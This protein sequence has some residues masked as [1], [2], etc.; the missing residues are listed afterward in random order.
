MELDKFPI[1]FFDFGNKSSGNKI[2]IQA[3]TVSLLY[4]LYS[5]AYGII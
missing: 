4:L 3:I 2:N 5:L 1:E